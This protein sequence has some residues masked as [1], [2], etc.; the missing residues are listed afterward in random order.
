[1]HWRHSCST[2]IAR[3]RRAERGVMTGNRGSER[4]KQIKNRVLG[5]Y[6][7]A[8]Y[9]GSRAHLSFAS[10]PR[11]IIKRFRC[12]A[13]ASAGW[14]SRGMRRSYEAPATSIEASRHW[15]VNTGSPPAV[16][17]PERQK[18]STCKIN[19]IATHPFGGG[20]N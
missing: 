12:E 18:T 3:F 2:Y 5:C 10:G 8:R 16:G 7:V 6:R 14:A 9:C 17:T 4:R 13:A 11:T 20:D 19:A 15:V 1:M